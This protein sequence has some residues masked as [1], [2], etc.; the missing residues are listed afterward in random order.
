MLSL[1][2][3]GVF[4]SKRT[5]TQLPPAI[6]GTLSRTRALNGPAHVSPRGMPPGTR[7][8]SNLDRYTRTMPLPEGAYPGNSKS[9]STCRDCGQQR[10][11]DSNPYIQSIAVHMPGG[12][13]GRARQ[14]RRYAP[15]VIIPQCR[16]D[17]PPK[18]ALSFAGI[19]ICVHCAASM[20]W[21]GS[22]RAIRSCRNRRASTNRSA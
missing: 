19:P 18:L 11:R 15:L 17:F 16:F 6:Q 10:C 2:G 12:A 5:F 3:A 8:L 4:A 20:L 13:K 14:R 1:N 7:R 21:M 22:P 9:R